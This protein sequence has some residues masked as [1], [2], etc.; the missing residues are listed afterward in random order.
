MPLLIGHA[1]LATAPNCLNR[2]P[3]G[4]WA[5]ALTSAVVNAV[6]AGYT[7]LLLS[8]GR[9]S[10]YGTY[11]TSRHP[12]DGCVPLNTSEW[13]RWSGLDPEVACGQNNAS[14]PVCMPAPPRFV[15]Q[16]SG[17]GLFT[18][19]Q[20]LLLVSV[21]H[22]V[23]AV[24]SLFQL[25][26]WL[27]CL[28]DLSL[29]LGLL[30]LT[31]ILTH[32]MAAAGHPVSSHSLLLSFRVCIGSCA[33]VFCTSSTREGWMAHRARVLTRIADSGLTVAISSVALFSV[34]G[35]AFEMAYH[36]CFVSVVTSHIAL[37]TASA[38]P[39]I[40][41]V[42]NDD[43]ITPLLNGLSYA[44]R[45]SLET[46][47]SKL[48]R[49]R[50]VQRAAAWA[51]HLVYACNFYLACKG[52]LGHALSVVGIT[53]LLCPLV[54]GQLVTLFSLGRLQDDTPS[55]E[56]LLDCAQLL[57]LTLRCATTAAVVVSG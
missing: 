3:C 13:F 49:A 42:G 16:S 9:G 38:Y 52:M 45:A 1:T 26:D 27:G 37:A 10:V 24:L 39:S 51:L 21:S 55:K 14:S 46:V 4:V 29:C 35:A 7:L 31:P 23:A 18:S 19:V 34:C 30:I 12:C 48:D 6:L 36:I 17:A 22:W 57:T 25:V 15:T 43:D 2:H 44:A 53:I 11:H 28:G 56:W 40:A 50:L 8:H 32:P 5:P 20:P 33:L 54:A 41:S 47:E